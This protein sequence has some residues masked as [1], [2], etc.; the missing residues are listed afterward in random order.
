[1]LEPNEVFFRFFHLVEPGGG[2]ARVYVHV[3]A[4]FEQNQRD[5]ELADLAEIGLD[6][7]GKQIRCGELIAIPDMTDLPVAIIASGSD[8]IA[9]CRVW[10]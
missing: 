1:M 6:Q 10:W 5:R 4:T 7:V 8:A 3:V 2:D 9:L